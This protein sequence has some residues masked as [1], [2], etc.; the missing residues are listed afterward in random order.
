MIGARAAAMIV[1]ALVLSCVLHA[2]DR[3][4]F[5]PSRD[6]EG[7]DAAYASEFREFYGL[8]EFSALLGRE[9]TEAELAG[10]RERWKASRASGD[11]RVREIRADPAGESLWRLRYRLGRSS[12]FSKITLLEDR[13]VPG[14]VFLVQRPPKDVPDYAAKLAARYGP[15]LSKVAELFDAGYAKPLGL[16]RPSSHALWPI[17]LLASEGD[18]I[19]YWRIHPNPCANGYWACYDTK[20]GLVVGYDDLFQPGGAAM[21]RR[22]GLLHAAVR[23]MIFAHAT[24]RDGRPWAMWVEEG[25][26]SYLCYHEGLTPECLAERRI[27]PS[28][29]KAIVGYA[30]DPKL[31][32]YVLHP[33]E[34]LAGLRE[35]EQ[36]DRLVTERC[37]A[38]GVVEPS[39]DDIVRGFYGQ[40]TLWMHF[41]HRGRDGAL[42]ERFLQY[43]KWALSANGGA[44]AL[45]LALGESDLAALD[46]E[47]FRWVFEE[48]RRAFPEVKVNAG[49]IDSL[50][51]ARPSGAAVPEVA[52]GG[53]G[54]NSKP[55]EPPPISP[56]VLA[57]SP[58][59]IEARHG[60]ALV[61][62]RSGDLEGAT[63]AL[64]AI[65]DSNPASPERDR[66]ARE[67]E[68]VRQLTLL[69]DGF[70]E[71]LRQSGAKWS[72]E[73]GGKKLVVTVSSV[74]GG[75]VHLAGNRL[76]V[77]RIP[78]VELDLLEIARQAGDKKEQ[79]SSEP[80]ARPYAYVLG[81]DAKGE[82]LLKPDSEAAKLLLEDAR[83]WY[84]TRLRSGRAAAV[85]R[86]LAA[87]DL[88]KSGEEGKAVAATIRSLIAESSD[89]P[90]IQARMG[91]LRRLATAAI[92]A[93]LAEEQPASLL[94]G[95]WRDLGEGRVSIA[96]EFESE[97]EAADF[98]K[99]TGYMS[100]WRKVL[101]V[102]VGTE[103][104]SSWTV[105]D[106]SF[107]GV[108][109]ACYRLPLAFAAPMTVRYGLRVLDESE[110]EK[111]QANFS[112]GLCDDNHRNHVL[113]INFGNLFVQNGPKQSKRSKGASEPFTYF[114]STDY[115][116]EVVH[117][118]QKVKVTLD[119]EP[120]GEE[121]ALG[122]TSG[123]VFLWFHTTF[124][125][126]MERFEIEGKIDP[127]SAV[128]LRRIRAEE[129]VIEMGFPR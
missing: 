31:R 112:V 121:A 78:L 42:R 17:G 116:F 60:L 73:H 15:W 8:E 98:V 36:L 69:R 32:D 67:I 44:D 18:Y 96:W 38:A 25:L 26:A 41:L 76:G 33:I 35:P 108:G 64:T 90:L 71:N 118:G 109:A 37:E 14:F 28:T 53:A 45:K 23:E 59:E 111:D 46:R 95:K 50:F 128:E 129:K 27:R 63:A 82:K 1:I 87:A 24:A 52:G 107:T 125:I 88:P 86:D 61:Q 22:Y 19:N 56:S 2:Q 77:D 126:A 58:T 72:I 74:E 106:G 13:T 70:L 100:E 102:D 92:G 51:L 127:E 3:P 12:Y 93:T 16:V 94:H 66:I 117:D 113:V 83:S 21:D 81:G 84:P 91:D 29:L 68:R 124:P 115:A 110:K 104:D 55:L 120:T 4:T 57:I 99:Q 5:D 39:E 101:K 47:F 43:L 103:A 54:A 97:A 49:V 65:Q 80:W 9:L 7:F 114:L 85:V 10:V 79:G 20:L 119:G 62:A 11:E 6:L 75:F 30:E 122:R 40:A 48:H 105:H 123:G 34:V 89:L